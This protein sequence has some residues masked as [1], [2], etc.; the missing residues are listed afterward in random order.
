VR[1]RARYRCAAIVLVLLS[2]TMC[3]RVED[4]GSRATSPAGPPRI[5]GGSI[6]VAAAGDISCPPDDSAFEGE[7][8]SECQQHATAALLGDADAV[9]ALGDLQ[10]PDGTLRTFELGYDVSWGPY[11][12][13]TYPAAGNHDYHVDG[14]TGYFDYWASKDRPTGGEGSGYYSFDLGS[15]HLLALNSECDAVSCEEGSSQNDFLEGDLMRTSQPCLLAFWH[16]PLFNSGATHGDSAPSGARAFWDDLT[17]ARADIVL[18]GH[19][20]NYQRYG[21]QTGAGRAATEGIRQFVVGTGGKSL[22]PLLVE[23]DPHFEAGQA[24]DFGVL[25][26]YLGAGAYSW[27]FVAI[28]G[29]LLDSGG[30]VPCN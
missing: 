4:P 27:E 18:N 11:A 17:A 25:K 19:E 28:D 7:D 22:Y 6:T 8:P 5:P 24:T 26:L 2:V 9:L 30:P 15:W 21:K 29:T 10:Y 16:H 23:K 12:D 1:A 3:A 13:K 14:A 20:H